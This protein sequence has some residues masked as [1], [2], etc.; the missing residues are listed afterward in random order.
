MRYMLAID[1]CVALIRRRPPEI[2]ARLTAL[3]ITEVCISAITA[4][5]LQYGAHQSSDPA[6][7]QAALAQFLLPRVVLPFDEAAAQAYGRVRA[8]LEASGAPIGSLDALIAAHALA[9]GLTLVTHNTREF[10]R[11]TGLALEDWMG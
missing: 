2:V 6:R 9:E 10:S 1:T 7:N 5:E 8:A 4:G 3:A 11:V